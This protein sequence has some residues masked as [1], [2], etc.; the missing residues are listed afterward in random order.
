MIPLILFFI[1]VVGAVEE[2]QIYSQK[3]RGL[4]F[5]VK[6]GELNLGI[7]G[8]K[9]QFRVQPFN[10][11]PGED[12]T[13]K[14]DG[15]VAA[16]CY[17]YF[18]ASFEGGMIKSFSNKSAYFYSAEEVRQLTL[19][20]SCAQM[21]GEYE[22]T[23][24]GEEEGEERRR[25]HH[26][27]FLVVPLVLV[28]DTKRAQL[29]KSQDE[30]RASTIFVATQLKTI[31]QQMKGDPEIRIQIKRIDYLTTP[32][33]WEG[34]DDSGEIL[35]KFNQWAPPD[36]I[37]HL[38]TGKWPGGVVGLGYLHNICQKGGLAATTT[39]AIDLLTAK[40]LA[41]ELG[42][43]LGIYHTNTFMRT[44][45]VPEYRPD[46]ANMQS[47]VMS[48]IMY[49]SQTDWDPCSLQWWTEM[50]HGNQCEGG[51]TC[52]RPPGNTDCLMPSQDPGS[53]GNGIR[54]EGEECDPLGDS[55]CT[56]Q[57]KVRGC[58]PLV[59]KCC[60]KDELVRPRGAV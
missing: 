30:L 1:V 15:L 39:M 57:C 29:F 42:H 60:T 47:S 17:G 13:F 38:L 23:V 58:S 6:G 9:R 55:C 32:S 19:N 40:V 37:S 35:T 3:G 25:L 20:T 14:G 5:G 46:C 48:P 21:G 10:A 33:T 31:Y 50:V 43:N 45:G 49:G 54:E 22:G 2:V 4:R 18:Y 24:G 11:V 59:S 7:G 41:H 44:S 36:E 56:S 53:C 26:L 12:C 52:L 28:V 51:D 34:S 8:K 27:E 16:N